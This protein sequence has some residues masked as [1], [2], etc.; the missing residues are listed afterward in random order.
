MEVE[1][2]LLALAYAGWGLTVGL[3]VGFTAIGTALLGTPGL[4][5]LFGLPPVLAVGTMTTA[6]FAM[7]L[8][9]AVQ[10]YRELNVVTAIAVW[11]AIPAVPAAYLTARY[12]QEI[13]AV[14]P[15]ESVIGVVIVVSVIVLFYRYVIL[16]PQPHD[17]YLPPW[18][19]YVSPFLGLVLG[20]LMGA[21]SI[22]GSIIV[23]AFI[24][25][26]KLPGP[27]AVGTTSV[28]STV[29]LLVAAV[30]HISRGNVEWQALVG[31]VPGVLLGAAI[32]ARNVNR[33]PRQV[34]RMAL[35]VI[36]ACAGVLVMVN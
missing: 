35:L 13:N 33:V 32:G 1:Y 30:A 23:I 16:R 14:V 28:V 18:K 31:L 5:I 27:Q 15:L 36:L 21:T 11:F 7:M 24:M 12:A 6:G 26:L 19:L 22:S 4:I 29:S 8:S 25:V 2:I 20:A 10:H 3:V 17:L 34:L 9:G